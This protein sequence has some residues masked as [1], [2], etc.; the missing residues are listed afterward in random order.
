MVDW[1]LTFRCNNNCISCICNL[2]MVNKFRPGDPSLNQI[3]KVIDAVRPG[4]TLCLTGGEPTIRKEFFSILEYAKR[5]DPN[6]GIFIAS[7]GR[8][9]SYSEYAKRL[10]K[11][12]LSNISFGI[13]LYGHT[14]EIHD[15]VTQ[16][17]GSFEQSTKGIRN[18]T[19]LGV[20]VEVR[21][22]VNKMNY[23]YLV[24]FAEYVL[25][26]FKGVFRVVFI[27]MKYT[28]NAYINKKSI[29]VKYEDLVPFAEKAASLLVKNNIQ[30]KLFHFPLC[31]IK[32]E[33]RG[34]AKGVTKQKRELKFIKECE[35][36]SAR[37]ECP[38]I[39]KSYWAIA[40]ES[41]FSAIE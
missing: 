40:G 41:E 34:M 17:P 36:C 16:S 8:M 32:E 1:P 26:N 12:G 21:I 3:K 23:K 29:F 30:V 35:K 4:D 2:D 7:N 31:T 22:I 28:G 18:L 27:N 39:W 11:V 13:A 10:I 20:P 24:D 6:I 15:A 19:G 25:E 38:M 9:F 37:E 5:R 14:T 33:F